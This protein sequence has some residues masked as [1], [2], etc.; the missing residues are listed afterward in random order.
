MSYFHTFLLFHFQDTMLNMLCED[1]ID[2]DINV[3]TDWNCFTS[4]QK[5]TIAMND[6][7]IT[8]FSAAHN[9]LT[10]FCNDWM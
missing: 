9:F 4:I 8:K 1:K 3:R 6:Q 10:P 7:F 2:I 5:E